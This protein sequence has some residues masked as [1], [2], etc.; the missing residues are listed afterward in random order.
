MEDKQ[1]LRTIRK[2]VEELKVSLQLNEIQD[3]KKNSTDAIKLYGEQL[4][5]IETNIE[6]TMI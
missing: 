1:E 3:L 6:D 4:K 5:F 2:D